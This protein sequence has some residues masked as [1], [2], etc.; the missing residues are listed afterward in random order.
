MKYPLRIASLSSVAL[1]AT[2][3]AC[4]G[5][6]TGPSLG[7][8][9]SVS[10]AS[11]D[12]PILYEDVP[13]EPRIRCAVTFR[14]AASGGVRATWRDASFKFFMGPNRTTAVDTLTFSAEEI[15]GSWGSS[16]LSDGQS[17]ESAWVFHGNAPFVVA[18]TYRYS[19]SGGNSVAEA[20]TRFACGPEPSANSPLPTISDVSVAPP[21]DGLEPGD[22]LSVGYTINAPLGIWA[23]VIELSGACQSFVEFSEQLQT[24]VSRTRLVQMPADC[25]LGVPLHVTVYAVDAALRFSSRAVPGPMLVDHTPPIIDVGFFPPFGGSL[26]TNIRGT[27]F[28]RDTMEL[29]VW[30]SDNNVVRWIDYEILPSGIRQSVEVT[31]AFGDRLRLVL[32]PEA[33]GAIQVRL[34]ARDAQGLTSAPYTTRP[35]SI[36]VYPTVDRPTLQTSL[37]NR[38]EDIVIDAERGAIY[39]MQWGVIRVLSATTLQTIRT[40]QLPYVPNS[41][42]FTPG[43]D[44]L[45]VTHETGLDVIDLRQETPVLSRFPLVLDTSVMQRPGRVV[46]MANGKAFVTL[47]GNAPSASVLLEVNLA[48]GEQRVRADAADAS[49]VTVTGV[50]QRSPD[51]LAFVFHGGPGHFRRYDATTDQFTPSGTTVQMSGG[52]FLSVAGSGPYTGFG[53]LI[54]DGSLTFVRRVESVWGDANLGVPTALSTDGEYLYIGGRP[55]LMRSRVS[56]GKIVDRTMNPIPAHIFRVAGDDSFVVTATQSGPTELSLIRMR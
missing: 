41:L 8:R 17:V 56:D 9:I 45:V 40:I 51:R 50:M 35:D 20:T 37:D 34:V 23:V 46:V 5:D 4:S 38:V 22:V 7:T 3:A 39:V 27:Y 54:Y 49:G 48:T 52:G 32:P 55:G 6:S 33:T 47:G 18:A 15:G 28:V 26:T 10:V 13:G 11:V 12:D 31:P 2:L 14:A 42:D 19:P 1:L 21:W 24:T 43:G 36:H 16:T 53:R 25:A 44:S 29:V 30:S